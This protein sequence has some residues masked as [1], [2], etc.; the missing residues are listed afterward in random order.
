ME[1]PPDKI[2]NDIKQLSVAVAS[3]C[4]LKKGK[5]TKFPQ[6]LKQADEVFDH[7]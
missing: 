4:S 1:I 2:L 3:D 6:Y 7:Q 5:K